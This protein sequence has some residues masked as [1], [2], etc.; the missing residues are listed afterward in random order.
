MGM[1][2]QKLTFPLYLLRYR[3]Y[4]GHF[5]QIAVV[6][7]C[8]IVCFLTGAPCHVSFPLYFLSAHLVPTETSSHSTP[9]V[10]AWLIAAF[11][12]FLSSVQSRFVKSCSS[13]TLPAFCGNFHPPLDISGSCL[14]FPVVIQQ[15][16]HS[17][18][19][20][21]HCLSSGSTT[22]RGL[23]SVLSFYSLADGGE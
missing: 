15:L 14:V 1:H 11:S 4:V 21:A 2:W 5:L 8:G 12:G 19:I 22:V 16:N 13:L 9:P 20:F 6:V 23:V 17:T 3:R 7:M 10:S 18:C